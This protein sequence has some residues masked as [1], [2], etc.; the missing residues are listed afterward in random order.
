MQGPIDTASC[1]LPRGPQAFDHQ[2][3][4]MIRVTELKGQFTLLGHGGALSVAVSR[5]KQN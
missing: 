3:G 5:R 1:S 4:C 2:M